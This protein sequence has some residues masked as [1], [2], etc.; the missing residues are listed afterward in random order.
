MD[1]ENTVFNIL[2]FDEIS[3][4]YKEQIDLFDCEIIPFASLEDDYL[5]LYYNNNSISVIYWSNERSL[6]SKEAAIFELYKSCDSF[7][8]NITRFL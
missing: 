5:C 3:E 8:R 4:S 1:H 2:S 7:M 6:E